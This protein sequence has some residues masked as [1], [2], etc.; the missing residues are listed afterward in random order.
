MSLMHKYYRVSVTQPE[1]S[2]SGAGPVIGRRRRDV[3]L[4][5]TTVALHY[6]VQQVQL[7][8]LAP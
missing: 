8:V 5:V 1:N 2:L 6:A 4:N 7:H 3:E